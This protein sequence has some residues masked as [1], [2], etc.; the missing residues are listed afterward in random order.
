MPT[1]FICKTVTTSIKSLSAHFSLIHS[2]HAIERYICCEENCSRHFSLLN[3]F[4]KHLKSHTTYNDGNISNLN[5]SIVNIQPTVSNSLINSIDNNIELGDEVDHTKLNRNVQQCLV[6]S[7]TEKNTDFQSRLAKFC[8]N[9]YSKPQISRNVVQIVVEELENLIVDG[10]NDSANI[11]LNNGD[12]SHESRQDVESVVKVLKNSFVE[13]NSEYKRLLFYE[14]IGTYIPPQEH[15]VGEMF[16]ESRENNISHL[17]PKSCSQQVIPLRSVLVKFFQMKNVLKDTLDYIDE[18]KVNNYLIRNFIEGSL[19][20]DKLKTHGEDLVLPFFLYFD[21]FEIGNPL[22]SHAGLHKIGALYLSIPCLPPHY[23]SQLK[24]IFVAQLFHSCDREKFGNKVVFSPIIDEINYLKTVG[25]TVQTENYCGTV[26][27]ELGLIVG[28]NLGLHSI[29]GFVESFSANYPCRYCTINKDVLKTQCFNDEALAR[30]KESYKNDSIDCIV[31]NSG[32]KESSIWQ[33]INGFDVIGQ[34]GVDVMHDLLEGVCKYDMIFLL[35]HYVLTVNFFS[36]E[37]LNERIIS[38]D[39]GPD[40]S[41][42]P[43]TISLEHLKKQNLRQSASEM[44]VLVRYFGLLVGDLVPEN[45]E[46]W[47]LYTL[48]REIMD[49]LLSPIIQRQSC[50]FLKTLIT[51]H[52]QLYISLSGSHL[53]PKFHFLLHYPSLIE[54]FGPLVKIWSMRYEAKHRI[55]KV[56]A[57]INSSRRN[58]CKSLAIKHQLQLSNMFLEDN[59]IETIVFGPPAEA[60]SSMIKNVFSER[61]SNEVNSVFRVS[62][63]KVKGTKYQINSVFTLSVSD[64]SLPTFASVKNIFIINDKLVLFECLP[65]KT[66]GYDEHLCSYETEYHHGATTFVMY[67]EIPSPVPN[68][69]NLVAGSVYRYIT[70]R[71]TI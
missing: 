45:D 5:N 10:V 11:L 52:H 23:T 2:D 67:N 41:S 17:V 31:S 26:K 63:V 3:S 56:S 18:C 19:W 34:M 12:I 46:V 66:I 54:K 40:V 33:G 43:V 9:L 35:S 6:A 25:I 38:F 65:Y 61:W 62:W 57:S 49:I 16:A 69:V 22:G 47:K 21:D 4:K 14:K 64:D 30:T 59:F 70:V 24:N 68:N 44:L 71:G 29:C 58:I 50:Q 32:I 39:F 37:T 28:D 8:S 42:K 20:Q 36:I 13:L 1:C 55:S 51:E 53:K 48:L 27:F 60:S 15:D 7:T